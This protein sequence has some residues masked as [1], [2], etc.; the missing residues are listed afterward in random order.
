[1][2]G[3]VLEDQTKQRGRGRYEVDQSEDGAYKG[4]D[5]KIDDASWEMEDG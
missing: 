3:L 2:Y 5:K 4:G 1:M